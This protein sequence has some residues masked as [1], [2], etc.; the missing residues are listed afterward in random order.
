MPS[1]QKLIKQGIKYTDKLFQEIINRLT[2]GVKY[3]DTLES[4]LEK[5]KEYTINNP[6]VTTGYD[7][8]MLDIILQETNNHKFSRPAQ[9]ELTRV[10]IE[11][12]VGNLIRGVGDDIVSD[13]RDIVKEG[14]NQGLSQ[15]EIAANITKKVRTINNTRARVIART[16]IATT[17]TISDYVIN[18]E[19]GATHFTVDCRDTCCEKCAL[20][21][22]WGK[23]EYS[24]EQV[25]M[26]PP[27]HPNCRCVAYFFKKEG[28]EDNNQFEPNRF[29]DDFKKT[30]QIGIDDD[31]WT[32][33]NIKTSLTGF[34]DDDK[35]EDVSNA[36]FDFIG[37]AKKHPNEGATTY[38]SEFNPISKFIP[39]DN[40]RFID[41]PIEDSN[42]VEGSYFGFVGH[43]HT[44]SKIP[45]PD[46][47]DIE[48][49]II[50]L[51]VEHNVIYAPAFGIVVIKK[52]EPTV[53]PDKESL[54][55]AYDKAN[56]KRRDYV[57][58][59]ITHAIDE[60][61]EK[62]KDNYNISS[63]Q[64]RRDRNK[65]REEIRHSNFKEQ[66]DFFNEELNQYG[67]EFLYITP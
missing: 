13:V 67:I 10:T 25:D 39:G 29:Y 56:G 66:L 3:S 54:K 12:Q 52:S 26:L 57:N 7:A 16:E 23:I 38:N 11:N 47:R 58:N 48:T 65:I 4:F 15:D 46:W 35:L 27:L 2:Q 8:G 17:A 24:M 63:I 6:L 61:K 34:I 60:Y 44:K 41:I 21:Y 51:D 45:L 32:K 19:R 40:E 62:N 28:A 22:N 33:E 18:R 36:I 55:E 20:N 43:S 31:A 64:Q 5:T 53:K 42:A 37:N 49:G 14:Y 1:Q 9:K 30:N 50:N 59:N